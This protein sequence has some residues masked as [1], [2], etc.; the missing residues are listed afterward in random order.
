M[1]TAKERQPATRVMTKRQRQLKCFVVDDDEY[2]NNILQS[3]LR[4]IG[5]EES[6]HIQCS[7]FLNGNEC[8]KKLK[9]RPDFVIL[10]FYLDENND[11]TLT[12]YDVLEK[13]KKY[14]ADIQ[15]IVVS[16]IHE[17]ENFQEEFLK[18]GAAGFLKK[19]E[20]LYANLKRMIAGTDYGAI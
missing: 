4:K 19:D 11:I 20:E 12:G 16:Q 9:E 17:W 2:F 6:I 3:Y 7:G 14:N 10:D 5:E 8:L 1:E 15:V 18:F 13:I